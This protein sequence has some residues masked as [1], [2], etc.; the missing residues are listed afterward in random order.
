M[1][2]PS[3]ATAVIEAAKD[4]GLELAAGVEEKGKL[5]LLEG[6][7]EKEYY[8]RVFFFFPEHG[9]WLLLPCDHGKSHVS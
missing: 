1:E 9:V 8:V 2:E 7:V 6:D 4:D 5:A 3:Q